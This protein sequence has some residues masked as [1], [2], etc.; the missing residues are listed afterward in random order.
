MIHNDEVITL[1]K[2]PGWFDK[3]PGEL[4]ENGRRPSWFSDI[5]EIEQEKI[6]E[7]QAKSSTY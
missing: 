1:A 3:G 6:S 7:E 5:K 4:D 2:K